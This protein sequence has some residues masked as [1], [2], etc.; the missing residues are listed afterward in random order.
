MAIK[1]T[2]PNFD[3]KADP[4]AYMN[5]EEKVEK[6]F[7]VHDYSE[8]KKVKFVVVEFTRH[9]SIWWRKTCRLRDEKCKKPI[10]S[11]GTLKRLMR[12]Q[13]IPSHHKRDMLQKL[14]SLSQG[15]KTIGEY[16]HEMGQALMRS[17]SVE[18]EETTTVRFLNGLNKHIANLM[19]LH[20][21]TNMEELH[22]LAVKVKRQL[23]R[24]PQTAKS[25]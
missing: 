23:K 4:D 24:M 12:K 10:S 15:S 6:I 1:M 5:W 22:Q 11:W 3:S 9:A 17:N 20:Q 19:E 25:T 13:Y 7:D 16:Y 14:Q 2:I 21:Y 8:R 18:D